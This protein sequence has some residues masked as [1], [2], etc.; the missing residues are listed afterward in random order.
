M[1][2]SPE[3]LWT[4][5]SWS[6]M[7]ASLDRHDWLNHSPS[8]PS[9]SQDVKVLSWDWKFQPSNYL[10]GSPGNQLPSLG[11]FQNTA[12]DTFI[13]LIREN[14]K[15]F[16]RSLIETGTKIVYILFIV[17]HNITQAFST[18]P[19]PQFKY[20]IQNIPMRNLI[21][22]FPEKIEGHQLLWIF[23]SPY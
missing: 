9:L 8:S 18:F 14:S 16:R 13:S 5:S 19:S 22:Y 3:A 12:R 23:S 11:A 7:E 1:F 2:T 17:N 20:G 6:F 15:S 21:L 10:V 4:S